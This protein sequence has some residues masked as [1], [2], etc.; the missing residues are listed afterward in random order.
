MSDLTDT[1]IFRLARALAETNAPAIE[2]ILAPRDRNA[3]Q[4]TVDA[5]E[6]VVREASFE[7][8]S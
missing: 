1:G 7:V 2:R 6:N 3:Y 4:P 8:L 5:H